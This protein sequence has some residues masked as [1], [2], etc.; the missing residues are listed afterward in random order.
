[1]GERCAEKRVGKIIFSRES[2]FRSIMLCHPANQT[3]DTALTETPTTKAP[4]AHT[5][6]GRC[7]LY[8]CEVATRTQQIINCNVIDRLC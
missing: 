6:D 7:L 5:R 4:C 2:K 8:E 1:M 3:M